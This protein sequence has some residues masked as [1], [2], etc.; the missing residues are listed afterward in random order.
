MQAI[1]DVVEDLDQRD[2]ADVTPF[3][4]SEERSDMLIK[5]FFGYTGRDSAHE[6]PPLARFFS[7]DALSTALNQIV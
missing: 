1:E 4:S 5:L 7:H 3:G 6:S 2:L